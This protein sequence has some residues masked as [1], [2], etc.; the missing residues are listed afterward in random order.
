MINWYVPRES[1]IRMANNNILKVFKDH[2]LE[3]SRCIAGDRIQ[4]VNGIQEEVEIPFATVECFK[5]D[6]FEIE[7]RIYAYAVNMN[8]KCDMGCSYKNIQKCICDNKMVCLPKAFYTILPKF[9]LQP[10]KGLE[11]GDV[12]TEVKAGA[13]TYDLKGIIKKNTKNKNGKKKISDNEKIIAPLLASSK[14]G[15]EIIRQ[16]VEQG[17]VDNR[18]HI[19]AVIAPQYID[20]GFKASLRYLARLS[21]KKIMF[22]ELDEICQLISMNETIGI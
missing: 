2:T 13:K 9:R 5:H 10:H 19:I 22:I 12:S 11:Y 20:N 21:G 6:D 16:F 1:L 3:Y 7:Q 4:I 15:E 14:E 18:C 17:M 8:E